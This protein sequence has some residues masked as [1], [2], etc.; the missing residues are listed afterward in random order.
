[1]NYWIYIATFAAAIAIFGMINVLLNRMGRHQKMVWFAIVTLVPIVG[2]L[3]YL[4][5]RN[6]LSGKEN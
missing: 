2:P 5:R 3:V 6:S 1:M 4:W